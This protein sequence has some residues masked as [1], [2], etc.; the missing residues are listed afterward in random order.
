MAADEGPGVL[1]PGPRLRVEIIDS[2]T[3]PGVKFPRVLFQL[4]DRLSNWKEFWVRFFLPRY[5]ET[6]QQNFVTEGEL[7]GGWPDLNPAYAAWKA[8]HFPGRKILELTRRLRNSLMP[9]AAGTSGGG[10]DTVLQVGP[11]ELVVGT[12][13]PYAR[14]HT[15]NRPFLPPVKVSDY[16]PLIREWMLGRDVR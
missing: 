12:R 16:T 8:R 3:D 14:W 9:G 13:V 2:R 10:S 11:R 5:L 4:T 15:E 6:V 7:V 1:V